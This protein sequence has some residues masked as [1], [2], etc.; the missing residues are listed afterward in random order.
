MLSGCGRMLRA[1][2]MT[3][4]RTAMNRTS[5]PWSDDRT[6]RT[7]VPLIA[8][9]AGCLVVSGLSCRGEDHLPSG[10]ERFATLELEVTFPES[11]SYLS[12]VRELPDG[13]LLAADPISEVLL[14]LDLETGTADTL[15][16]QGEGP[17]EWGQQDEVLPLPGDSTLVVDLGNARLTVLDPEGDPV[18][19]I[20]MYL[21]TDGGRPR[22][23]RPR[24]VDSGGS[25]YLPGPYDQQDVPTDS[26][27]VVRVDRDDRTETVVA[28]TW[29]PALDYSR[30]EKRPMLRPADDWAAGVDGRIAV[31]R[32]N[33]YSID[34]HLPDGRVLQGP[35]HSAEIFPV[36]PAEREAEVMATSS[37]AIYTFALVGAGGEERRQ[38]RRGLPP[39]ATPGID[40]FDWPEDLPLFRSEGTRVSPSM[41]VWVQRMM[42][43]DHL[44]R[45]E[46]FDTLG[47]RL[48]YVELPAGA[49]LI[50]FGN[51]P[52][53][54]GSVYLVLTDDLGL[55]WLG[56]YRI[57]RDGN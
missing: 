11:F 17:Q 53:T 10:T 8:L 1:F 44:P 33:G 43:A 45:T 56:R 30:F 39:G 38:T 23:V 49:K 48:G 55:N 28:W 21:A 14:R 46:V 5:S 50:G 7:S 24:F 37:G 40:E 41:E 26:G 29:R 16:S 20:P 9:I 35:S 27:S 18:Q 31:V 51:R 42:P 2:L 34:W 57:R 54:E 4:S 25:L 47:V 12:A 6:A 36:G 15:G 13:R 3:D 52:G 19:W 22:S 32:A